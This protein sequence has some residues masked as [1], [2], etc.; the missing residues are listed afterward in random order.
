MDKN[1]NPDRSKRSQE[2]VAT[3]IAPKETRPRFHNKTSAAK[4]ERTDSKKTN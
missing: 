2:I 1:D 4:K 3:T